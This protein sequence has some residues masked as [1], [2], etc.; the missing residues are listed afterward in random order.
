MVPFGFRDLPPLGLG[1]CFYLALGDQAFFDGNML[2]R[3]EIL[4]V[5]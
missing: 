4:R 1:T 5:N 2:G 3:L